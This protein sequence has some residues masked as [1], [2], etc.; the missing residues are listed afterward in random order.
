[1]FFAWDITIPAGRSEAN[2]LTQVL[3]LTAG[4]IVKGD[5]KFPRG[6]HGIVK[7]RL[8]HREFQLVPLSSGEWVTGDDETISFPE[9]FEI[10]GRPF[11]LKFVGCS[12]NSGYDHT[13]TIRITMLPRNIASMLP[14]VEALS[15]LL[16]RI[17]VR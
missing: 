13:I 15:R 16:S 9:Y 5:I 6:C 2:P 1:M 14:V 10:K 17:G 11:S 8:L 4:V 7:V 3:K 12:P